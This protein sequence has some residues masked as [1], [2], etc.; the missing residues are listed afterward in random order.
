MDSSQQFPDQMWGWHKISVST[1]APKK[2]NRAQSHSLARIAT[3]PFD[4]QRDVFRYA[5]PR[6]YGDL[7]GGVSAP[8]FPAKLSACLRWGILNR[9]VLRGEPFEYWGNTNRFSST[10]FSLVSMSNHALRAFRALGRG[11]IDL[12][13]AGQLGGL[14]Q[15]G[16]TLLIKDICSLPHIDLTA[17]EILR[18]SCAA[19][20]RSNT[21]SILRA[22][23]VYGNAPAKLSLDNM[24][25]LIC[26]AA[27]KFPGVATRTYYGPH[28]WNAPNT[29]ITATQKSSQCI[30]V[31]R[32][33][34]RWEAI[35]ARRSN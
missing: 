27:A 18:I 16:D 30:A 29:I 9:R 21:C 24:H 13:S 33:L 5:K 12:E 3:L 34:L 2:A 26:T 32:E 23:R 1:H 22:L 28:P 7:L 35:V 15:C 6:V 4:L 20:G 8:I 31:L 11:A 25:D 10:L 14:M 17:E 19:F